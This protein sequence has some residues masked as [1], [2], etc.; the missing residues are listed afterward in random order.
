VWMEEQNR[1]GEAGE[2][3]IVFLTHVSHRRGCGLVV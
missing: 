3:Q 2:V 1:T